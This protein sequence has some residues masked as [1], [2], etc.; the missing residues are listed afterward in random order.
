MGVVKLGRDP[1]M[2]HNIPR[3]QLL[4]KIGKGPGKWC[5]FVTLTLDVVQQGF[6]DPSHKSSALVGMHTGV[7]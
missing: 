7:E 3:S 6:L 1:I 4:G 2:F 5:K